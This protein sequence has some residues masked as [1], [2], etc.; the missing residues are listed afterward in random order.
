M[1]RTAKTENVKP[2]GDGN[3][4]RR[5]SSDGYSNSMAFLGE[6]SPL[7]QSGTYLRSGLSSDMGC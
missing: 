3:A 5:N 6:A 2:P 7:L 4:V 1:K